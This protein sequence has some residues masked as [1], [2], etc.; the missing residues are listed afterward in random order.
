MNFI[1]MLFGFLNSHFMGV[2]LSIFDK[3]F[4]PFLKILNPLASLEKTNN[5]S[6][7]MY[8]YSSFTEDNFTINL[9]RVCAL[10]HCKH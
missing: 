7:C 6:P 3:I 4:T 1:S 2:A 10:V 8:A 9:R 5:R